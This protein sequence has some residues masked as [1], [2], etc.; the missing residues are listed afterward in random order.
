[1]IDDPSF[2]GTRSYC[3]ICFAQRAAA[4]YGDSLECP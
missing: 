2:I 3:I 4:L 1:M